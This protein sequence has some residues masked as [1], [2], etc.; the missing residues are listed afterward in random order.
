M[1]PES[2][3]LVS[4]KTGNAS[5]VEASK[6]ELYIVK[7]TKTLASDFLSSPTLTNNLSAIFGWFSC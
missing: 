7:F 3:M 5:A 2:E 6:E 4:G 1:S